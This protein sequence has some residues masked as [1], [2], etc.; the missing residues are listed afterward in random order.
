METVDSLG[1]EE[2]RWLKVIGRWWVAADY[3]KDALVM[4]YRTH[5]L[6]SCHG[7]RL[8]LTEA[9]RQACADGVPPPGPPSAGT[10]EPDDRGPNIEPRPPS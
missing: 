1:A 3:W 8:H 2:L 9:G 4:R 5:G 10:A 7:G 6:V